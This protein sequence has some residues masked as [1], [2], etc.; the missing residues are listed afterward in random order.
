[1]PFWQH[2]RAWMLS[3]ALAEAGFFSCTNKSPQ[4][5]ATSSFFVERSGTP[6]LPK[7]RLIAELPPRTFT[8]ANALLPAG[9]PPRATW[10]WS[11]Q[12][13]CCDWVL[14]LPA[15]SRCLASIVL[16]S[17]IWGR[18][19]VIPCLWKRFPNL[20]MHQLEWLPEAWNEWWTFLIN[21]NQRKHIA[22]VKCGPDQVF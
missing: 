6:C 9:V 18:L 4:Q 14:L 5:S 16:Y 7:R 8:S 1:M 3:V 13:T 15:L 10:R 11:F 20:D 21:Q 12:F 22:R 19:D 2:E 17:N